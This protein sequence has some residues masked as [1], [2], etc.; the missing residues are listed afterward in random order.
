MASMG[1]FLEWFNSCL[2]EGNDQKSMQVITRL[3]GTDITA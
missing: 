1:N 3:Q 2:E